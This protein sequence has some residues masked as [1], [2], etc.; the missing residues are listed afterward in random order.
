MLIPIGHEDTSVRRLPWVTFG[1]MII[2]LLVFLITLPGTKESQRK[3]GERLQEAVQYWVHHPYLKLDERLTKLM[4]GG[5]QD[6]DEAMREVVRQFGEKPPRDASVVREQQAQLQTYVE[7]AFQALQEIPA[8]K[9]GLIPAHMKAYALITHMFMHG[10]WF[11]LLG[12]LFILFLTGPFLEDAWGRPVFASFYLVAGVFAALMYVARYPHL[13][14]PLIGA[15]GAIAGVMGAFLIRFWNRKIRFFYWFGF[16]FHGTFTAPAWLMLGLWLL[17]ELAF[18]Q[19][20]DVVAPG[21]GG[22]GVAHWAHVWGFAFGLVVA[23]GMSKLEIEKRFIHPAIESKITLVD[24]T[25]IDEAMEIFRT[26]DRDRAL[27]M[28]R[29]QVTRQRDNVDAALAYWNMACQAGAAAEAA[30]IAAQLIRQ[31]LRSGST[32][33]GLA[34][35]TELVQH[36]P[37]QPVDPGTT[38]TVAEALLAGGRDNEAGQALTS[39]A[40]AD[41]ARVPPGPLA[42]ASRLAVE[43]GIPASVGL[44]E[45]AATHP[46]IPAETQVELRR[47]LS[48]RRLDPETAAA[49]AGESAGGDEAEEPE[50]LKPIE[51]SEAVRHTLKIM[52]AAPV[53]LEA[54]GLVLSVGGGERLLRNEQVLVLATVGVRGGE[55]QRPFVV[56]DLLLD[57]PWSET[58]ALR[59]VRVRSTSFDPRP[60]VGSDSSPV[61]A[62]RQ[63]L[64]LLLKATG[65]VP[66]PDPESV[67]GRPFAMFDSLQEYE[68]QILGAG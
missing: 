56:I 64:G 10:G 17:R 4:S 52:E 28:L 50:A 47:A 2:C 35:W 41:L 26:G 40:A 38:V 51:V 44:V 11:H 16:I 22:G 53:R 13:S 48:Q 45:A 46:D 58:V 49:T 30:P 59:V 34:V 39:L 33:L 18:A 37:E 6:V 66:L 57:S 23:A 54:S 43:L 63:L 62:L 21:S 32:E 14:G 27:A 5:R 65:A 67:R 31:S 55:E 12:N 25:T 36:A 9:L 3:A 20:M 29:D 68:A 24:N 1:I 61:D 7:E 42:R 15:S 19:A 8:R 60:I